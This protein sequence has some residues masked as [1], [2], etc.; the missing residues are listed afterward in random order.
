MDTRARV[1]TPSRRFK[2]RGENP[3]VE[4]RYFLPEAGSPMSQ[5]SRC[6]TLLLLV[7]RPIEAQV[8]R[9]PYYDPDLIDKLY[10]NDYEHVG[11]DNASRQDLL[12][13]I[14]AFGLPNDPDKDCA[15]VT[16]DSPAKLIGYVKFLQSDSRT[17]AYPSDEAGALAFVSALYPDPPYVYVNDPNLI[18]MARE[19]DEHSCGSDRIQTIRRNFVKLL[20]DRV[21]G[22]N[23]PITAVAP[24]PGAGSAGAPQ[25]G[26][27]RQ[28]PAAQQ[29]AAAAAAAAAER[30]AA[31]RAAAERAAAERAAAQK[32]EAERAAAERAAQQ[33]KNV[34]IAQQQTAKAQECTQRLQADQAAR[35][36]QQEVMQNYTV[37]AAEVQRIAAPPGSAAAAGVQR[38]QNQFAKAQECTQQ[39]QADQSA[40]RP[41]QETQQRY[42]ACLQQIQQLAAP[43]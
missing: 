32:A 13:V 19:I 33:A 37:C 40:G 21:A 14:A 29:A 3:A 15:F 16:D 39:L 11:N 8:S 31:D 12:A 35:R 10:K 7:S 17:G 2:R 38:T 28:D 18:A 1:V 5:L 34:Q 27:P 36:P 25:S 30:A 20:D 41:Q 43:R 26:I 4:L 23:I 42:M 22:R 24:R 6:L 9:W